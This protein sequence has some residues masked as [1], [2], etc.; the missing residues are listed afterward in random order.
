VIGWSGARRQCVVS[1]WPGPIDA[2]CNMG[3]SDRWA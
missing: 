3:F 1:A 2:M